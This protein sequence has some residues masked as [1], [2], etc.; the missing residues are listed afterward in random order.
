MELL[1]PHTRAVAT[2]AE[3]VNIFEPTTRLMSGLGRFLQ[4]KA[5]YGEAEPLMRRALAIDEVSFES[6]HPHVAAR[7]NN[8]LICCKK[9]A[10]SPRR[11]HSCAASF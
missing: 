9:P 5:L 11:S 3:G 4:A 10:V 7:L 2:Y 8:S 1:A 6:D